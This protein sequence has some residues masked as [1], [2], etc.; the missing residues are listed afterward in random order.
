MTPSGTGQEDDDA[1]FEAAMKMKN[2]P[3]VLNEEEAA[4]FD[5]LCKR[6]SP[7]LAKP[8]PIEESQP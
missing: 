6:R 3:F 2:E 8:L 1:R 5:E 4:R 7:R